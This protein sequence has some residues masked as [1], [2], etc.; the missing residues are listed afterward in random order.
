MKVENIKLK[1]KIKEIGFTQKDLYM[2]K[3]KIKTEDY[4]RKVNENNLC[5]MVHFLAKRALRDFLMFV[6]GVLFLQVPFIV[7]EVLTGKL[8]F[9]F[10]SVA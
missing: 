9:L 2:F 1:E 4:Q 3:K 6:F 10:L 8:D 5:D 7:S